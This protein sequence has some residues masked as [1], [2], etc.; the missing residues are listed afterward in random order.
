MKEYPEGWENASNAA[1]DW[2]SETRE[3]QERIRELEEEV[4]YLRSNGPR[5]DV[6]HGEEPT[7][8]PGPQ[9]PGDGW[10]ESGPVHTILLMRIYDVLMAQLQT[11]HPDLG[12]RLYQAHE[13]GRV[14]GTPPMFTGFE[15][16]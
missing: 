6:I 11:T 7:D 12:T 16:E 13:A 2:Q 4:E 8:E 1:T 10:S 14:L 15:E 5:P 3:A 9:E